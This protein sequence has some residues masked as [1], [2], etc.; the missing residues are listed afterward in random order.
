MF[1]LL[2]VWE[3][4]SVDI[5]H[6][7]LGVCVLELKNILVRVVSQMFIQKLNADAMCSAQVPHSGVF[8]RFDDLNTCLI[9]FVE[10]A[11][12]P[13]RHKCVPEV[14]GWK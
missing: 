5:R 12:V 10:D 14:K 1:P 6:H 11:G 2:G 8:A 4:L 3:C 7:F 9:V 13:G